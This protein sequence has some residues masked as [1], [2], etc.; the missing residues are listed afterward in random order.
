MK[1]QQAQVAA[2]IKKELRAMGIKATAKSS[3]FSMGDSVRV[4]VTDVPYPK[5]EEIRGKF[6]IYEYGSF[7]AMEDI[8]EMDNNR[9]DIPQTK[10]LNIDCNYTDEL[11][12]EVWDWFKEHNETPDDAPICAK[13]L[14]TYNAEIYGRPGYEILWRIIQG[15]VTIWRDDKEITFWDD[16]KPA[17]NKLCTSVTNIEKH[18]HT[19]KGFNMFIVITERTDREQY[20]IMLNEAKA[21]GGWYSR[22][23]G[24][25]PG[26]FAFKDEQ[27]AQEFADWLSGDNERTGGN[28]YADKL[29]S[30]ADKMQSDIDAKLC[31]RLENTPKRMAQ[32]ARSRN[33]GYRLQR[34]QQA[35][36]ALAE[37]ESV[38]AH[39]TTKKAV[40]DLMGY[41]QQAVAHGYHSYYVDTSEPANDC[42][43]AR[44]LFSLIEKRDT[45]GD[46]IRQKINALKF[47]NIPGYFPTP[48]RV[49]D[50]LLQHV[51]L[52]PDSKVLEPS[53][54]SGA[55]CDAIDAKVTAYEVNHS[56]FEI[57]KL[58]GYD[59]RNYDFLTCKP[60]AVYDA[61]VM[62]PPFENTQDIDHVLHAYEFLKTGGTLVAVMSPAAFF[63]ESNKAKAFREWFNG[64]KY[65]LPP[66]SFKESGTNVNTVYIV[67]NK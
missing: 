4:T 41:K 32:A 29:T 22:K 34:T 55:I 43:D 46:E 11:Y 13:E 63:H 33:E 64:T 47:A 44:F 30:L 36:Y 19:K 48:Q 16:R 23:W 2:I 58:K 38:P 28:P 24:K 6:S 1:S 62:N 7:N 20:Q 66:G 31:D 54:G 18:T 61:V 14:G 57:L 56:L 35:L 45:T 52:E 5:V 40:Y 60:Q 12:Q 15:D 9:A 21:R 17:E 27:A 53:A 49:I 37:L 59:A 50:E 42:E 3:S 51:T 25:T 8:Y 67:M 10:Y 39:L 26:G 65:E